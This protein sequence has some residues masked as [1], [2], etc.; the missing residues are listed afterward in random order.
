[1]YIP[2]CRQYSAASILPH[3]DAHYFK[4]A[5]FDNKGPLPFPPNLAG[6]SL[7]SR[8]GPSNIYER[9]SSPFRCPPEQGGSINEKTP[10]SL[11][12]EN[13]NTSPREKLKRSNPKRGGSEDRRSSLRKEGSIASS[14]CESKPALYEKLKSRIESNR[15]DIGSCST[16]NSIVDSIRTSTSIL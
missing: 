14:S 1:M 9:L 6:P 13:E 15:D 10:P 16:S 11:N 8:L 5:S 12:G 4:Q 2:P 7:S 3:H